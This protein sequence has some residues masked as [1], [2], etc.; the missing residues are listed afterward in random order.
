MCS[1]WIASGQCGAT[2]WQQKI[3][4]G[5]EDPSDVIARVSISQRK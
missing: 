4:L 5:L 1:T 3:V 2:E